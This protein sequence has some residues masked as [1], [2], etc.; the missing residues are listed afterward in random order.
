VS[1][2][3]ILRGFAAF[4]VLAVS[5]IVT[6][7]EPDGRVAIRYDWPEAKAG[8]NGP[9]KLRLTMTAVVDLTE[10]RL[11]ARIP[12]NVALR[13]SAAGRAPLPW[14]DE[15][16][17]IGHLGAGKTFVLELDVE[18]PQLGGGILGFAL[19]GT[20]HDVPVL[21]GIGVP[22]GTPGIEPTLRNGALE[23]PA[24]QGDPAP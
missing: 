6:A 18:K 17:E 21:E 8:E 23:F 22:V 2:R 9:P 4:A 3:R 24:A 12:T 7:H 20:S 19:R 11:T 15:G 16:L 1:K 10:L 13:L 5:V 14:P